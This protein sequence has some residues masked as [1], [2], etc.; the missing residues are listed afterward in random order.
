MRGTPTPRGLRRRIFSKTI[1]NSGGWAARRPACDPRGLLE[2]QTEER[3][4]GEPGQRHAGLPLPP[5]GVSPRPGLVALYSLPGVQGAEPLASLRQSL[6]RIFKASRTIDR[7]GARSAAHS[8]RSRNRPHLCRRPTLR[9]EGRYRPGAAVRNSTSRLFEPR[10]IAS[11][12]SGMRN[13]PQATRRRTPWR[14]RSPGRRRQRC[15][16]C[17]GTGRLSRVRSRRER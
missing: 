2:Q 14:C 3:P 4:L 10:T 16:N 1:F 6:R 9:A 8:K 7:L 13:G 12:N 11:R 17:S 15:S 5:L